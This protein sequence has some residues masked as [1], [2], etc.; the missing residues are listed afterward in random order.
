MPPTAPKPERVIVD[1]K[2]F[3][4]G[5]T[6]FFVKGITYGPFAANGRG[7]MFPEP[8]QADKDLAQ[9]CGLGANVLR[10]YD[11]PPG[12]F[13]DSAARHGLKLL[14]DVPWSKHT[15]F[16]E[17]YEVQRQARQAVRD[18]VALGRGH[19]ALFALSLVNEVPAEIVRWSGP[20]RVAR[21]IDDLVA[22]AKGIDPACLCTF[23][24]FPP[25]EF[26]APRN[27]DFLCF[28][29]YLEQEPAFEAY[30]ARLQTL[31][32]TKPLLLGEFGLDSIRHG[33]ERKCELLKNQ[34]QAA[35]RGGLAGTIIFSYT[36]D[37]VRG[38]QL[39]E[40][41][42]F[43]LTTRHRA[44]KAS[45]EQVHQLYSPAPYF[46]LPRRPRVSVVVASFNGGRT[47]AA[48]LE[49][50]TRLNYPDYEVILID[51]GSTDNTQALAARFPD[52]R[53]VRQNNQG[54]S[55]ARNA[56]LRAATGEIVAFTDS[57]CR[58]DPDWLYY[59]VGG[60][61]RGDYVGIGGPNFLPP[62]DS[63]V[64]AAVLAAPGGPAHVLLTDREAEHIP[65]CNMAFYKWALE[66][67]QGF[68]PLFRKAGDD[69]DVC[70]RLQARGY[71]LGFSPAGFVWHY[72]RS[73]LKAYLK[74]QSG[75]GEAEALLMGKHPE[76]FNAFGGGVWRGRI[77]G[78]CPPGLV[79]RP[80]VIYHG[81]F[82]SGFFQKL[83]Q[84]APAHALMLCT[85]L[86]FHLLVNLPLLV[87]AVYSPLLVVPAAAT[88]LASMGICLAA[89]IQAELPP[90]KTRWWSRP[91]VAVLFFLQPLVRGWTCYTTRLNLRLTQSSPPE[92]APKR[93]PPAAQPPGQLCFSNEQ[94]IDRFAFL[95][96]LLAHLN[97][98]GLQARLDSG[99]ADHDL[100]FVGNRWVTQKLTTANEFLSGKRIFLRCRIRTSWS[101]FARLLFLLSC[102]GVGLLLASFHRVEPWSWFSLLLLPL[103]LWFLDDEK[104]SEGLLV[105][106]LVEKVA[107]ELRLQKY[108]SEPPKV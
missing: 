26:L 100:E 59:L 1:G 13:L 72:R 69:V 80:S 50:L 66:E 84:P 61:V 89:A 82:G 20:R 60:L 29:V 95:R 54:L 33:E 36:D 4:L 23:A 19:P 74:Q 53:N 65:G 67:I 22:E 98:N 34:V 48:C 96:G 46:P 5:A 47:L 2:F 6:R 37:W 105:G 35:C 28:N 42:G 97:A 31:A 56:G 79:L 39:I 68:D 102:A 10:V 40:D 51:D 64:A 24:S 30:L 44:P 63:P 99:W 78:A 57:D 86:P 12:W 8:A 41:W 7:E 75:Y 3:R 49:S 43:G 81:V 70:W 11:V 17:S 108:Q 73:T 77:Y 16:F 14:V 27:I 32:G 103:L 55:A 85:S 38:G 52:V 45:F 71:K 104:R 76:Y 25:T 15:C 93:W 94:G 9:L 87:L 62:E 101:V 18:A 106:S 90:N 88:I 91:L 92:G 83:Y 58:A 107:E 21:F